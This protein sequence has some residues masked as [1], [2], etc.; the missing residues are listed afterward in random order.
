MY[1]IDTSECEFKS[2]PGGAGPRVWGRSERPGRRVPRRVRRLPGRTARGRAVREAL[3][4]GAGGCRGPATGAWRGAAPG[5]RRRRGAGPSRHGR[6][7]SNA[8]SRAFARRAD[9]TL[10]AMSFGPSAL[11]G[12]P[13][14]GTGGRVEYR[15]ARNAVVSEFRK[16]RLSRLDV[17]DA[18]PE[19]L[20]AARNV[21]VALPENCPICEETEVV[22]VTYVFGPRLPKNGRCPTNADR[23][24]PPVP[25]ARRGGLL[26]GRGVPEVLVEPPRP[27]VPGRRSPPR[28]GVTG[29]AGQRLTH[30][31]RQPCPPGAPT[32]AHPVGS[33]DR[34]VEEARG[35]HSM[36]QVQ[37][38]DRGSGRRPGAP[39]AARRPR[40]S[41]PRPRPRT[42]GR[43]P[44]PP[45]DAASQGPSPRGRRQGPSAHRRRGQGS[46][47]PAEHE[48]HGA[49]AAPLLALHHGLRVDRRG[50]GDRPG[51]RVRQ[52][53]GLEPDDEH[54]PG[55]PAPRPRRRRRWWPTSPGSPPRC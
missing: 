32:S 11:R 51:V 54:D 8:N 52:G 24:R 16:G 37:P 55:D 2:F 29:A 42:K 9:G 23:A 50:R 17:C 41:A 12:F 27:D 34:F 28:D 6:A 31:P 30:V 13:V 40:P 19:L 43:A 20:R 22:H 15:L 33:I 5:R 39:A 36:S 44:G 53:A 10:V 14:T 26:R 49:A 7:K 4:E 18:H 38:G 25:A 3:R 21:G 45:T 47:P 1:R 48:D 46:G 35:P